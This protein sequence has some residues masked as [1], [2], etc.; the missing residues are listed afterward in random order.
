M[1][2]IYGTQLFSNR[3]IG[4]DYY[5]LNFQ[6]KLRKYNYKTGFENRQTYGLRLFSNLQ[7]INFELE[8]AY[9]SG[10]FNDLTISAYNI[11]ADVN[12]LILPGKKGIIGFAA[13]A[14]S[15]DKNNADNKLNT[16]NLL[17]AKPAYGLAVPIGA[18]N[19]ISFNPYIKINPVRK[20]NVLA[21]VFFLSRNSNQDGTYSPG[22]AENRP[23]PGLVFS[24]NKKALGELYV[25]ETNYQQTKNISFAID[26]S[27]FKAG[28]YTKATG[29]GKDVSYLSFKSTFRF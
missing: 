9:Q 27:Y 1:I 11:L 12:V 8:G 26:A 21:Q 16:Y 2:G 29:S 10:K 19:I 23:K 14:S 28:S 7:Q 13:N 6:S 22:M 20:L 4:F 17:Y 25:I 3:K 15:G 18:A 5:A 24:T